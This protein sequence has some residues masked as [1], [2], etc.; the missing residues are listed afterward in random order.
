MRFGSDRRNE[1][2]A[3]GSML[4]AS[5]GISFSYPAPT[6]RS[7]Y[8]GFRQITFSRTNGTVHVTVDLRRRLRP[9]T[10]R[11][12]IVRRLTGTALLEPLGA[13]S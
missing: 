8:L 11:N 2:G 7:A 9:S 4:N 6:D 10:S 1:V 3:D 12:R 13:G 5:A